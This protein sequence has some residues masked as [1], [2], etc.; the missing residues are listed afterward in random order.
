MKLSTALTMLINAS[1]TRMGDDSHRR[2]ALQVAL[3]HF[4]RTTKCVW[5]KGT[6]SIALGG[7]T[8]SVSSLADFRPERFIRADLQGE[9][10]PVGLKT[11][12]SIADAHRNRGG[13][14]GKPRAIAFRADASSGVTGVCWPTSDAAYTLEIVY[15]EPAD[16]VITE[17]SGLASSSHLNIP[18][19]YLPELIT[20]GASAALEHNDPD[21]MYQSV[22]W[23]RFEKYCRDIRASVHPNGAGEV[24]FNPREYL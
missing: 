20:F 1:K 3:D 12:E 19:E 15:A 23:Q 18:D 5:K 13:V 24:I 22:A 2:M 6:A 10:Q 4:M 21:A 14:T 11:Y 16:N 7:T 9:W 8:F 17:E